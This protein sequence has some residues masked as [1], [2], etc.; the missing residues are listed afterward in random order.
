MGAPE[1]ALLGFRWGDFEGPVGIT[2]VGV[3]A[4]PASF[5]VQGDAWVLTWADQLVVGQPWCD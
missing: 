2:T 5:E 3:A 1:G 4:T